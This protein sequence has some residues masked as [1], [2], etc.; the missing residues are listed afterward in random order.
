[1]KKIFLIFLV[2]Y[3]VAPILIF[4][5]FALYDGL[6]RYVFYNVWYQ[7]YRYK[8]TVEQYDGILPWS[9]IYYTKNNCENNECVGRIFNESSNL[10]FIAFAYFDG[11]RS[12]YA[13]SD[14]PLYLRGCYYEVG[15][16]YLDLKNGD[17]K[18]GFNRNELLHAVQSEYLVEQLKLPTMCEEITR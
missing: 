18:K 9:E 13:P 10:D 12:L 5:T 17:F 15:Y 3:V 8:V 2:V 11:S 1:M 4:L 14:T 16:G 7:K 6:Y